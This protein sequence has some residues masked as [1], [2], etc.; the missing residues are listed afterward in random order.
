MVRKNGTRNVRGIAV[1]ADDHCGVRPRWHD[2][3][4]YREGHVGQS[5]RIHAE[6]L[7]VRSGITRR[8]VEQET[9]GERTIQLIGRK[10]KQ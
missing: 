7:M 8:R 3:A 1:I 6:L 5:V 2:A 4:T 9:D 10:R